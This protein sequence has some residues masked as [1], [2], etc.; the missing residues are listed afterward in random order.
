MKIYKIL[1]ALNSTSKKND[2]ISILKANRGNDSFVKV[3]KHTYDKLNTNYFVKKMLPV[4]N[5]GSYTIDENINIVD[6]LLFSLSSRLI[7]GKEALET[8]QV[9]MNQFDTNSQE[10]IEKIIKRDLKCGFSENSINKA[11][12]D[13][14]PTFDVALAQSYK[15]HENKVW[16]TGSEWYSSRKMDGIQCICKKTNNAIT[17][18]SRKGKQFFTLDN[19]IPD[20][21][22]L[23]EGIDNIV[24]DGE[25]CIVDGEIEDFT[26]IQ[27]EYNRKNHT[28]EHPRYKLFDALTLKE[29]NSKT[30]TIS[31]S[32]R[33]EH[34]NQLFVKKLPTTFKTLDVL[35][36]VKITKDRFEEMKKESLEK[37]WEGLIL[38]KN[39]IYKGTR[40]SDILKVKIF[41][42]EEF[43]IDSIETGDYTYTQKD[44]G[45]VTEKMMLRANIIIDG[46]IVNGKHNV[47][48]GS[49][50]SIDQRKEYYKDQKKI[51]GKEITVKY[52]GRS[53]NQN[54][55]ESLRFPTVKHL[56]EN[57]RKA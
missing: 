47:G 51:I 27:S 6:Q 43:I 52:F 14:I 48:V 16:V 34:L 49:G 26:A 13:L 17:F 10:I 42:D 56:Y 54:G 35:E 4:N 55:G 9:T 41:R 25:I 20:I 2:K 36:Q 32:K 3:L 24:F 38:R 39:V 1:T 5:C 23:T 22:S 50:W 46:E 15:D 18:W 53:L 33:L 37:G 19:I 11:I 45:Q 8:I 44:I 29:F 28:I 21:Q 40:S 57:G 7:T 31:F 12:P 30:S